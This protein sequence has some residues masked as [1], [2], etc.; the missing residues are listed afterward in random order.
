MAARA[1]EIN[2]GDHIVGGDNESGMGMRRRLSNP[3]LSNPWDDGTQSGNQDEAPLRRNSAISDPSD[4][5]S[6]ETSAPLYNIRRP[7]PLGQFA[8]IAMPILIGAGIGATSNS[9]QP[10]A[11]FRNSEDFFN[12]LRRQQMEAKQNQI[13]NADRVSQQQERQAN[14][15]RADA[16]A[17]YEMNR[18]TFT[19]GT[20]VKGI[21]SEPQSPTN[22][23]LVYMQRNPKTGKLE[24]TGQLVPES[25]KWSVQDTDQ[26]LM[27]VNL[28]TGDVKP[29]RNP[30]TA[31]GQRP[32]SALTDE[33][34][35]LEG[36]E[37]SNVGVTGA[38]PYM[39]EGP[40]IVATGQSP[41]ARGMGAVG[42]AGNVLHRRGKEVD[43]DPKPRAEVVTDEKG[44]QTTQYRDMNSRSKTYGQVINV[45]HEATRQPKPKNVVTKPKPEDVEAMAQEALKSENGDADKAIDR[46][47]KAQ[48]PDGVKQ[49][50]RQ[51]IRE[52]K[53]PGQ[54]K[55]VLDK[56]GITPSD[57]ATATGKNGGR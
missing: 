42:G 4:L 35:P 48:I 56:Y 39:S 47:T 24:S 19:E 6:P 26:G 5:E 41:M 30:S 23:K 2:P 44:V 51:R 10:G 11:G 20:L 45:P 1:D 57:L 7:T 16:T 53:R 3:T 25:E 32:V 50:V 46:I 8:K 33:E 12:T 52:I 29:L 37:R 49:F 28:E 21:D 38:L 40:S 22:G 43:T 27:R 36:E 31:T 15:R 55:S 9:H 54:K 34:E 13:L 14:A 18:P 17:N